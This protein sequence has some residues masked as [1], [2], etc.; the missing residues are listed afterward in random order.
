MLYLCSK[1]ML[2]C[3]HI[4]ACSCNNVVLML[5]FPYSPE[6]FAGS[7]P[8]AGLHVTV[9]NKT[10]VRHLLPSSLYPVISLTDVLR[11]LSNLST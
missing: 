3:V 7:W 9:K 11:L 2:P 1:V 10:V 6:I 8:N 4:R 5:P